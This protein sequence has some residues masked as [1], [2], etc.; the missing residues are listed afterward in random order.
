[1]RNKFSNAFTEFTQI[2]NSLTKTIE[3]AKKFT[4]GFSEITN[5]RI[6]RREILAIEASVCFEF[7]E[8]LY[9]FFIFFLIA[10]I[11]GFWLNCCICLTLRNTKLYND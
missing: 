1:M 8:N 2:E 6:V 5:C 7:A 11:S 9:Y 3:I 4:N 10:T